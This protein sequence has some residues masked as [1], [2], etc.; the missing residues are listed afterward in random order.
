M[1]PETAPIERPTGQQRELKEEICQ[2]ILEKA[3]LNY[4]TEFPENF[5]FNISKCLTNNWGRL[6]Y[7]ARI[8]AFNKKCNIN[9]Y[10]EDYLIDF[11]YF[12]SCFS[13]K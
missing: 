4:E 2:K 8:T 9:V 11:E 13:L 12:E 5:S 1:K 7:I 3:L 10:S 6:N